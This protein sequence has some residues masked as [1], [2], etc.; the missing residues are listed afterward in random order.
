MQQNREDPTPAPGTR[1]IS[2]T[3]ELEA[4]QKGDFD[5]M[6]QFRVPWYAS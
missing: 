1:D 5:F 6:Q 2:A 3:T 4:S